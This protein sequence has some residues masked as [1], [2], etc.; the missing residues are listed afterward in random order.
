M[1]MSGRHIFR[2]TTRRLFEAIIVT[3]SEMFKTKAVIKRIR[4]AELSV[5]GGDCD[6]HKTYQR[7]WQTLPDF[8]KQL[9]AVM[10]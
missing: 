3:Y 9:Q 10:R 7:V 4:D 2:E 8:C 1:P 6:L 5:F